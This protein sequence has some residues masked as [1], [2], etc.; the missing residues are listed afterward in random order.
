M[1]SIEQSFGRLD[2]TTATGFP[3]YFTIDYPASEGDLTS[4]VFEGEIETPEGTALPLEIVASFT[5]FT[6]LLVACEDTTYTGTCSY[7]IIR[8]D[9]NLPVLEF[10]GKWVFDDSQC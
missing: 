1:S 9:N 5:T 7:K 2:V 4:Q 10:A 3:F 6:R 8:S